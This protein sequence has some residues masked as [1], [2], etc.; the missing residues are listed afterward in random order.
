MRGK[1]RHIAILIT[2]LCNSFV[3]QA[4]NQID[5]SRE[6]IYLQLD[7]PFYNQDDIIRFNLIAL[8]AKTHLPTT[9]S[10]VVYVELIDPKGSISK[11]LTLPIFDGTSKGDFEI[12]DIGGLYTVKAYTSWSNNFDD[13]YLLEKEIPVQNVITTRLLFKPDFDK[14]SYSP[15]ELVSWE[16][17]ISDLKD[18]AA[19]EAK[20]DYQ[21]RIEGVN[22]EENVVYSDQ[23]GKVLVEFSLPIDLVTNDVFITAR[24]NYLG[25]EESI[26]RSVPIVLNNINLKFYPEGGHPIIGKESLIAF[27]GQNEFGKGTAIVGLVLDEENNVVTKFET[28]HEGM[29]SFKMNY[30]KGI[31][32]RAIITSPAWDREFNLPQPAATPILVL[33]EQNEEDIKLRIIGAPDSYLLE[34]FSRGEQVYN[35]KI[36]GEEEIIISNKVLPV[37]I[38]RFALNTIDGQPLSERMVFANVDQKINLEI[39]A[40][41]TNYLPGDQVKLKIKTTDINGE[42]LTMKFGLSVVDDQLISFADDRSDHILSYFH[43]SS[44][45]KGTIDKPFFY[46]DQK[47]E[48]ADLAM[49]L[50]MLVYGW[51]NYGWKNLSSEDIQFPPEKI[52]LVSGVLVDKNDN[53][54]QGEVYALEVAGDKRMLKIKTTEDGH[55]VVRNFN[56]VSELYLFTKKP[57]KLKVRDGRAKA[58]TAS[59]NRNYWLDENELGIGQFLIEDLDSEVDF[60]DIESFSSELS[61]SMGGAT[62]LQEVVVTGYGLE[63]K[64]EITGAVTSINTY[65]T[66]NFSS[67]NALQGI[68]AGVVVTTKSTDPTIPTEIAF[69]RAKSLVSGNRSPMVVLNG[70]VLSPSVSRH[71]LR[72]ESFSPDR[73]YDITYMDSPEA[74]MQYGS[75]ASNGIVFL[76][77][78]PEIT[79]GSYRYQTKK[80]KY[81]GLVLTARKFSMVRDIYQRSKRKD[82][83]QNRREVR[84]YL[85]YWNPEIVT[86]SKGQAEL[87]FYA[88]DQVS[89]FRMIGEG[90]SNN[91]KIG[92]GESSFS[93][94]K[95]LSIDIKLPNQIGYEDKVVANLEITNETDEDLS[96]TLNA[97]N[98]DLQIGYDSKFTV[99]SNSRITI[100]VEIVAIKKI[101]KYDLSFEINAGKYSDRLQKSIEIFPVGFP[102]TLSH[103]GSNPNAKFKFIVD[104]VESGSLYTDLMIYPDVV[105]D[106]E[107]SAASLFREPHGCFEQVSSTIYPSILALQYL[108]STNSGSIKTKSDAL[109]YI[110]SGYKKLAAYEIKGGGFEWFGHTPAHEGLSA[111]GLMEFIQMKEVYEEVDNEM[112]QRT[113]DWLLSRRDGKGGFKQN[114]GKYGFSAASKEVNNA[115]LTYALSEVGIKDIELEY[116]ESMKSSRSIGDDYRLALLTNASHN[117][118]K[119]E[120]YKELLFYFKDKI[121]SE[122]FG[123]IE[124]DH[125]IVRSYGDNLKVE[126]ASLWAIA[127]L[128][129]KEVDFSF[130]AEI[131]EFLLSNRTG[132]HFGSTQATTLALQAIT[133]YNIRLSS[134]KL[135][136]SIEVWV[137]GAKREELTHTSSLTKPLEAANFSSYLS[138]SKENLLELRYPHQ[139]ANL[140]YSVTIGWL[141]KTPT[142]NNNAPLTLMANLSNS[143][144]KLNETVRMTARISNTTKQGLPMAIARLGIPGGLSL[145]TWQL[146]ELLEK[147]TFDYYEIINEDLII[148]FKE[149]GPEQIIEIPLD[150]KAEVKGN[151]LGRAC[152][153]YLYYNDDKKYW[154]PGLKIKID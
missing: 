138:T 70:F 69:T 27:E 106:L 40:D 128:K 13:I 114:A 12:P 92:R 61:L 149:M 107:S 63:D 59:Q 91:G 120:L 25:I 42:P 49:D 20:V 16:L 38:V 146:K 33:N 50:L 2:L 32:Y 23:N 129:R 133:E 81:N 71:F 99:R 93:T 104:N 139:D 89:N 45:L 21:V 72:T 1:I 67:I 37:G 105:S 125:S 52:R 31:N 144:I 124:A 64:R 117:L 80:G 94:S 55:F 43:L 85:V 145:Q 147:R 152:S 30:R 126:V 98:K 130:V 150:L 60:E 127:Y 66:Q 83:T 96:G 121:R 97:E 10:D 79:F 87:S 5:S 39:E 57:N 78:K 75:R 19:I 142:T 68:V 118:G 77:T 102:T 111:F 46:F 3:M 14:K 4:Q 24:V 132:A 131:I 53:P 17:E 47:E 119:E 62:E 48:K 154:I 113:I 101:G 100:P 34:G 58:P 18:E 84:D 116:Q 103:S 35:E 74:R 151:Y 153:T 141:N 136:G 95:L 8:D 44:E 29:G 109:R 86:D 88:N 76:E 28:F 54:T 36:N 122:G 137:N 15:G 143:E 148:Y 51:S 90:I 140:P 123:A 56:P 108:N 26:S 9:M 115:Y 134:K 22:F 7:K 41:K 112:I 135:P 82:D 65:F 73:I 110:K 11:K 6:K